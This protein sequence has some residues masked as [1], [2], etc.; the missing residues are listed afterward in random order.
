MLLDQVGQK[1]CV[2]EGADADL[3]ILDEQMEIESLF[4]RG[5]TALWKGEVRMKGRFE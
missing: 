1:G 3:L 2:A 4:A 5:K